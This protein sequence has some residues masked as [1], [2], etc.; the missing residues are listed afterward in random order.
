MGNGAPQV[1]AGG[2][3][4]PRRFVT[5]DTNGAAVQASA[6]TQSIAG[7]S[8]D[9]TRAFNSDY[10]CIAGDP[11]LFQYSPD[12]VVRCDVG[13]AGVVAGKPVVTDANGRAVVWEP[14]SETTAVI[15]YIALNTQS[16]GTTVRLYPAQGR[17]YIPQAHTGATSI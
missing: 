9:T 3:I 14:T 7:V 10:C 8:Q 17:I 12:W 15:A 4:Y 2:N 16:S 11:A 13:T 6:I 5:I 1:I